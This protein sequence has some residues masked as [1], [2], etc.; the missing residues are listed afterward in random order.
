MMKREAIRAKMAKTPVEEEE[1]ATHPVLALS[2][3]KPAGQASKQV[4]LMSPLLAPT[5][6][7]A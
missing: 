5:K 1:A 3:A 7:W 2:A 4:L 6:A